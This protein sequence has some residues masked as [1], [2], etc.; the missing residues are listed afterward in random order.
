MDSS[1]GRRNEMT[2]IETVSSF[3]SGEAEELYVVGIGASAGGLEALEQLFRHMPPNTGFGFVVIQHLSPDYKSLMV[4]LL[5]KHTEMEVIKAE[6]KMVVKPDTVYVLPP[7]K[8]MTLY[9][10]KILLKEKAP[11][12]HIDLPIDIFLSS[13]AKDQGEKAIGII[14]SG[15]GSDGTRGVRAIKESGGLIMVQDEESAKFDG[16]PRSAMA[17]GVVDFILTPSEIPSELTRYINQHSRRTRY[18]SGNSLMSDNDKLNAIFQLIKNQNSIDFSQ[19]KPNTV[20]RRIQRRMDINRLETLSDYLRHLLASPREVTQLCKEMLIGVTNFFRDPEAYEI[21]RKKI[22]PELLTNHSDG[23][24][25]RVWSAGCSSGEEAYTLAILFA[26]A[27]EDLGKYVE[28]KIFATDVDRDA[29]EFASIGSYPE[30]IAADI[31]TPYLQRYFTHLNGKYSI[32]RQIREMIVFAPQNLIK[33]PP[34]T[35]IDLVS[36]RNLLIYLQPILQKKVYSLFSFALN[37]GGCLFLGGSETVGEFSDHFETIDTK[38]KLYKIRNDSKGRLTDSLNLSMTRADLALPRTQT[39]KRRNND[40]EDILENL[41]LSLLQNRNQSCIVV[42]EKFQLTY[43]FGDPHDL[44]SFSS[45]KVTLDITK[46]VPNDL[47]LAL[48]T[49]LHRAK[50]EMKP[51]HYKGVLLKRKDQTDIINIGVHL[52]QVGDAKNIF[53]LILIELVDRDEN[54]V[55]SELVTKVQ[56]EI[57]QHVTD[58]ENDLNFTRENLQATVEELETSNE[59]LQ[60]ANE[61][62]LSSNE[63]LQSTNEELQSVNEELFTVNTEYQQ[64]LKEMTELNNDI[65]NLMRCTD[66]GT[67]FLDNKQLI[68]R[69]TP[70]VSEYVNI[71]ESDIGRKFFDLAHRL[72]YDY[73]KEDTKAVLETQLTMEKE[74]KHLDGRPILL[75]IAPYLDERQ[76]SVGVIINYIDLTAIKNMELDLMQMVSE[77]DVILDTLPNPI[78]YFNPERELIWANRG[79]FATLEKEAGAII[80]ADPLTIW[81][82]SGKHLLKKALS[83][84][85]LASEIVTTDTG[86]EWLIHDYPVRNQEGGVRAI[87]EIAIPVAEK[88]RNRG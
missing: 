74:V 85:L 51:I 38:Y 87:V 77:K 36:C 82:N 28:V 10:G 34:F 59:E 86:R 53:Y 81:G 83:T 39:L 33:D 56:E 47:S 15:T 79:A 57:S 73:L 66:I 71:I 65:E 8:T 16:M 7:K 48:S 58:L 25:V 46:L 63:E 62:L 88:E 40:K 70:A 64:K 1:P 35:K 12:G 27:M 75:K 52:I 68:R 80:G 49:A 45:G 17:T 42:N 84:G 60:A 31:P 19:Y 26:E 44:V 61:E 11:K 41:I 29:L 2:V 67:V 4:E 55:P 18:A 30:S 3:D 72:Q 24:P 23:T 6:D 9:E 50:K 69:F 43:T 32:V 21:L 78:F 20:A 22:I 54:G 76:D 13:L 5:S 14:L 37:P